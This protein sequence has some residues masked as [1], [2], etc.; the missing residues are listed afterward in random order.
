[1]PLT[2]NII[3]PVVTPKWLKNT[4]GSDLNSFKLTSNAPSKKTKPHCNRRWFYIDEKGSASVTS[5]AMHQGTIV[6]N[7]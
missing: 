6:Q 1:M 5:I 3:P 4:L 7:F 2:G